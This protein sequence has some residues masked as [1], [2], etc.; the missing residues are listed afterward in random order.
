M[1]VR[2]VMHVNCQ[3]HSYLSSLH[4]AWHKTALLA[5]LERWNSIVVET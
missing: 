1:R 3:L 4:Q 5:V 2:V